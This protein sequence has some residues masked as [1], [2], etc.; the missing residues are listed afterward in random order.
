MDGSRRLCTLFLFVPCSREEAR[1][2]RRMAEQS[3][4][5]RETLGQ[6]RKGTGGWL[7]VCEETTLLPLPLGPPSSASLVLQLPVWKGLICV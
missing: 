6:S 4:G 2:A 5:T 1:G 3:G 7:P